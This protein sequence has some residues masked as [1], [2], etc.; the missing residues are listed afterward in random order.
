MSEANL[1]SY[2]FDSDVEPAPTPND[3]QM[4]QND[5]MIEDSQNIQLSYN[6]ISHETDTE[7]IADDVN[8]SNYDAHHSKAWN[9]AV[10]K[11]ALELENEMKIEENMKLSQK[12]AKADAKKK[13]EEAKIKA[14][15]EKRKKAQEL[16]DKNSH[17][18]NV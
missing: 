2:D 4:V 13:A 14:E 8:P 16:A 17:K 11:K 5:E 9:D 15:A 6:H 18:A 10:E 1:P 12:K 7:D 3:N